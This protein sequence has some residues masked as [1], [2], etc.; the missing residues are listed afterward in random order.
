MR[1]L[2]TGAAGF[3]GSHLLRR[4]LKEGFQVAALIR[5]ASNPWRIVD[6]LEHVEIIKGDLNNLQP[7]GC[8]I[9]SFKPEVVFHLAWDGASSYRYQDDFSQVF[10]NVNGSLELVRLAHESKCRNFIGMGSVLEY[11]KYKIPVRE[12]DEA[13]PTS[14][15][16]AAKNSVN[17]LSRKLCEVGGMRFIWFRLFWAYGPADEP[18]RMIPYLIQTLLR[19]EKAAL[20]PG[21]QLWDYIFIDDVVE[22]IFQAAVTSKLH[23]VYNLASGEEH[24]IRETAEHVRDLINP[25]MLLGFGEIPYRSDQIMHLKADISLLKRTLGWLPKVTLDEGLKRTVAW[26]KNRMGLV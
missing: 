12:D 6:L 21:E 4:L 5:P 15:Y 1:A 20:T 16:G 8:A 2:I 18:A 22:A 26:H 3:I 23:G 9:T 25:E 14:L 19:G 11:G 24:S 7:S 13:C 17:M 10:H